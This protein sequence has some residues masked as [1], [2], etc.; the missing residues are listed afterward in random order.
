MVGLCLKS[1][2]STSEVG[3][4]SVAMVQGWGCLLAGA[5][6][7]CGPAVLLLWTQVVFSLGVSVLQKSSECCDVCPLRGAA[8]TISQG[9]IIAFGCSSLVSASP[10]FSDLQLFESLLC[11]ELPHGP[12]WFQ[13]EPGRSNTVWG[14]F[15]SA[16]K[17]PQVHLSYSVVTWS[18]E[19]IPRGQELGSPS[20]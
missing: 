5:Q 14:L 6:G 13:G 1:C 12:A 3:E 15:W 11:P 2:V 19:P 8:R 17:V 16:L 7:V 9:C 18:P 4:Q 10:P 20:K